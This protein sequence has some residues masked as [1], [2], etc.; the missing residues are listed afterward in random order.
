M[1]AHTPGP[2]EVVAPRIGASITIYS[3]IKQVP[4]ATT[5]SNTSKETLEMHRRG[6]VKA[7]AALIA[8]APDLLEALKRCRFDSLNMSLAD[9][10]FCRTAIVKATGGTP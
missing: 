7:N 5:C 2:W 10:E 4:I 9:L 8:A 1:S 3:S 6:E